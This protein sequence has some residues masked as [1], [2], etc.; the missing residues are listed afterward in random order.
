[1]IPISKI[2]DFVTFNNCGK[3]TLKNISTPVEVY[4]TGRLNIGSKG[5]NRE[6]E[7]PLISIKPFTP[8][9]QVLEN[10]CQEVTKD[11]EK[12]L[13][14]KDWI[15]STVQK[16]GYTVISNL[17][18]HKIDQ[19]KIHA[20]L[21]IPNIWVNHSHNVKETEIY[22]KERCFEDYGDMYKLSGG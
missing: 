5:M 19:F 7:E 16:R 18:G 6:N 17:S 14:K 1:M 22:T 8:T 9:S 15:H 2:I 13:D 3:Q 12:Y 4:S 21:S 11:L 10:F 20:G